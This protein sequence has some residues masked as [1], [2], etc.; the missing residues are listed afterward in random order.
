M[1]HWTKFCEAPKLIGSVPFLCSLR[2]PMLMP[3]VHEILTVFVSVSQKH[4]IQFGAV[5]SCLFDDFEFVF[6]YGGFSQRLCEN[7]FYLSLAA[8]SVRVVVFFQFPVRVGLNPFYRDAN[9]TKNL[10]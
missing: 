3:G 5:D 1:K 7:C 4:I 6:R 8:T 2:M 10:I 9:A